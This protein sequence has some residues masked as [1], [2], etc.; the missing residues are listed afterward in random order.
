MLRHEVAV[1]RRQVTP[2]AGLGA[3]RAVIAAVAR[4]LPGRLQL[5]RIDPGPRSGARLPDAR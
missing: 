5:H 4:L 2:G 1:L 3:D